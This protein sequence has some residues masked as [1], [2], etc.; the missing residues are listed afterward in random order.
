M[1]RT[2]PS[3]SIASPIEAHIFFNGN[4]G[5][6]GMPVEGQDQMSD[7]P[8]P[9]SFIVI[10]DGAF[11]IGGETRGGGVKRKIQSNLAH[12]DYNKNL[13]VTYKDNGAQIAAGE[14]GQ[15]GASVKDLGGKYTGVLYAIAKIDGAYKLASINLRGR[16]LSEWYKFVKGKDVYGDFAY[17][18]ASVSKT[19]G[20]EVDSFVPSFKEVPASKEAVEEA[21][22]ADGVLQ[23]WLKSHF[24]SPLGID[25]ATNSRSAHSAAATDPGAEYQDIVDAIFPQQAPPIQ[26]AQPAEVN[27]LP[28]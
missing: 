3:N 17:Q 19:Q 15:I 26:A 22:A 27:D 9:F 20:E 4:S 14:W 21:E 23:A 12:R 5:K 24:S 28:F 25:A 18:I 16:A 2:Q 8:L 7:M 11:R 1:S 13:V 6:I 10:D